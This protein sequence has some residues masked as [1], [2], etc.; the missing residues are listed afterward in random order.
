MSMAL[1]GGAER[2]REGA[3]AIPNNSKT[4]MSI[5]EPR[6]PTELKKGTIGELRDP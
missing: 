3:S 1:H 2:R 4:G 6:N 5:G